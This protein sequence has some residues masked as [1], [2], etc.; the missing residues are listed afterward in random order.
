MS[1]TPGAFRLDGWLVEPSLNRLVRGGTVTHLRPQLLDILACL[2]ARPGQVVSKDTLLSTVWNDRFVA[3]TAVGRCMCELRR[4]LEDDAREPRIIETVAKR[5]YRL[6]A[7]V[8]PAE[9]ERPAAPAVQ[10]ATEP[11]EVQPPW[12]RRMAAI[13]RILMSAGA[14]LPE[15]ERFLARRAG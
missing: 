3:E 9:A 15:L 14:V 2:A 6:L 7:P 13:A 5:G 4:V 11:P 1:N 12:R 10:P 8:E